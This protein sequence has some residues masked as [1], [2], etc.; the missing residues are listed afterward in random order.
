VVAVL[1]A[2][3]GAIWWAFAPPGSRIVRKPEPLRAAPVMVETKQPVRGRRSESNSP[4][5]GRSFLVLCAS[6][7]LQGYVGYIFVFWSFLYLREVRH[8][9]L[10]TAAGSAALPMLANIFIIPLGGGLSDVAV[11]RFGAT[12]GRRLLPVVALTGAGGFL[13]VA[14]FTPSATIAVAGLAICTVLVLAT[15]GPYWATVNQLAPSRGGIAGGIMNFGA[16]LGGMISPALTPWLAERIGWA[17]ALGL[18]AGLSVVAGLLWLGVS[19]RQSEPVT[20]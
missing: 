20:R 14:A 5:M 3:A 8:F 19:I 9:S 18:A 2:A 15:E 11:R 1:T 6:Y 4:L 10:A 17:A 7:L 12:W 13:L 16:N